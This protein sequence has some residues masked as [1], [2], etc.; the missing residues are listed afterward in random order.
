M[1]VVYPAPASTIEPRLETVVYKNV[2]DLAS[3]GPCS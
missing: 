2:R 3:Q 1:F